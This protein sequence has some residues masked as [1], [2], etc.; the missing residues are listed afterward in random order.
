MLDE[1][2]ELIPM[3]SGIVLAIKYMLSISA[4]R[5]SMVRKSLTMMEKNIV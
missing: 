3:H 5:N 1:I 4:N 2:T